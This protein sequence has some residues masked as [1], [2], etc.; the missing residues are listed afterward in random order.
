[1]DQP[2]G[3]DPSHDRIARATAR[4]NAAVARMSQAQELLTA[5]QARL[6]LARLALKGAQAHISHTP[7]GDVDAERIEREKDDS[8]APRGAG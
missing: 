2:P 3:P 1:M 6:A 7:A 8:G 5:A 4:V